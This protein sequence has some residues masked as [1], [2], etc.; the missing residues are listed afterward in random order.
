MQGGPLMHI[1]SAKAVCFKEAST[2]EFVKYSEQVVKI[3]GFLPKR[4][5]RIMSDWFQEELITIFVYWI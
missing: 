2:K 4:L 3:P 5:L 1:I